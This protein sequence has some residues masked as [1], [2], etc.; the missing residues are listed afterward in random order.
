VFDTRLSSLVNTCHG[1]SAIPSPAMTERQPPPSPQRLCDRSHL[2]KHIG[3]NGGGGVLASWMAWACAHHFCASRM[4][5]ISHA[6]HLGAHMTT[7]VLSAFKRSQLGAPAQ[8]RHSP[9]DICV[10][11]PPIKGLASK[12]KTRP[13]AEAINATHSHH[14]LWLPEDLGSV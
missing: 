11:W 1:L 10:V 12:R 2:T 4:G 7:S 5:Q 8:P 14:P 3:G 13:L 6:A 9:S